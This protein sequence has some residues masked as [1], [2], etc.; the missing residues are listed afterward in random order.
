MSTEDNKA[1]AYQVYAAI[2]AGDLDK[3]DQLFDPHVIRHAAGEIGI[4]P[5]RIAVSNA[6]ATMPDKRFVV[7]DLFAEGNK[8]ALRVAVMGG[9][10]EP[11]QHQPIIL[12]IFR[13][14]NGR[15]AEIWGAG[16]LRLPDV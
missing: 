9:E 5:A 14:E 3:L 8:V 16:G 11:G 4:E 1:I 13:I 6:F 10:L 15:V 12:E 2:N 7:E